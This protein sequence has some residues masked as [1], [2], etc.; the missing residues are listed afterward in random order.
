M[1]NV[2]IVCEVDTLNPCT[3][4]YPNSSIDIKNQ[5]FI[6]L[7]NQILTIQLLDNSLH[8]DYNT[9]KPIKILVPSLKGLENP[10]DSTL[11]I[12]GNV[13]TSTLKIRQYGN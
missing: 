7:K 9:V 8:I 1:G 2:S 3:I 4:E 13:N 10:Y 11:Y 12:V 5:F 6:T